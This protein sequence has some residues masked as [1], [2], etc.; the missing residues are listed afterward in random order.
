MERERSRVRRFLTCVVVVLLAL[1]VSVAVV[2]CGKETHEDQAATSEKGLK[3]PPGVTEEDLATTTGSNKGTTPQSGDTADE[4]T[5]EEVPREE[6]ATNDAGGPRNS[7]D[8]AGCRFT[9]VSAT[10]PDSNADVISGDSREVAGDY[11]EIELEIENVGD[12]LVDLSG[13]SFRLE[14]PGIDADAY[15]DYYGNVGAYGKYVSEHVIS[16]TLLDYSNLQPVSGKLKIGEV[17]DKVFIFFDLNP[18]STARNEG[19]TK[20]NT[21]FLIE[22]ESGTDAGED[23]TVVLA[24]YPD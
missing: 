6:N 16:G 22:K 20:E 12:E 17:M 3:L 14:S 15:S 4:E 2:S 5:A 19:V 23:V 13:Y 9:V 1:A 10:R 21:A 18:E 8:L 24:G 7:G 11:L